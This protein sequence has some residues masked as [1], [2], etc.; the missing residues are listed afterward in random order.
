[1]APKKQKKTQKAGNASGDTKL[2]ENEITASQIQENQEL[3][4]SEPQQAGSE[5]LT[6]NTTGTVVK[7]SGGKRGVCAMYKVIV[8]KAHGKKSKVTCDEYGMPNGETRARLQSYIGMLAR[9]TVPIDIESWPKVDPELK[10]KIWMDIQVL[11]NN[12]L[13]CNNAFL[14]SHF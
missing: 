10:A 9:T 11:C 8:K 6:V 3:Q 14:Y 13:V 7:K 4:A 1:M 2:L 12:A 5:Q